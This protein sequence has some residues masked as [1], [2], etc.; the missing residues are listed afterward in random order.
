MSYFSS[1]YAKVIFNKMGKI[2]PKKKNF[3]F[4]LL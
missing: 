2:R 3:I 4:I 1:S